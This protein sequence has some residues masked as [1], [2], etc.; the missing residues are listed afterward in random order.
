MGAALEDMEQAMPHFARWMYATLRGRVGHRVLD[1]GAGIGTYS[2]LLLEDGREVVA[3]EYHL[4]FAEHLKVRFA[5]EPR[6]VVH[7]ADLS[8]AAGLP[9]FDPVDS[10]LCL[11]VLEHLQD[12]VQALCNIRERVKPGGTLALLVPAYCW[13]YNSI[14]GAI[15]HYRRYGRRELKA[16]LG[17]SGWKMESIFRF[18][19]FGVPGWFV[20]GLLRRKTPGR[21][22]TRLYDALVPAFAAAEKYAIRGLWGLS[23]VALCRNP[24]AA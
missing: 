11:N 10:A 5:R 1:A 12:D 21:D 18:N 16:R 22:L 23:L 3:L 9:L 8:A 19:S 13:L 20:S 24:E 15:G 6:I 4:P 2:E 14:D 7:Q 17:D